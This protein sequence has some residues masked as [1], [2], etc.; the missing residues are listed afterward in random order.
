VNPPVRHSV[1]LAIPLVVVAA[2]MALTA[3]LGA[4]YPGPPC[5]VCD[6]AGPPISALSHGDF[7][8][9][10]STQTVMGS[11]SLV[12]RAPFAAAARLA[13]GDVLLQYRLGALACLLGVVGF[14]LALERYTTLRQRPLIVRLL[15]MGL[16]VANPLVFAALRWG[17]PEEALGAVLCAGAILL[18]LRGRSVAAGV[19][20]GLALATKQWAWL[21][22]LPLLIV[23]P[24]RA[25]FL[26]TAAGIAAVFT[27]PML[28]GDPGRF[29]AQIHH[30]GIP[31][32]GVTPAN[33]W[34]VYGHE[35]GYELTGGG[36]RGASSYA[37][38]DWMGHVS[39]PLVIVVALLLTA[40]YWRRRRDGDPMDIL[41]LVALVFLGR[42]ML[43][44]L[45]YSYHSLPFAMALLTFEATRRRVPVVSIYVAAWVWAMTKF[46]APIDNPTLL[47]RCYLAWA[48]PAAGYL[49][50]TLFARARQPAQR[51]ASRLAAA[52]T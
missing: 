38:P 27:L 9:F 31:G 32:N 1:L 11:F 29:L 2:L 22:L 26:M 12:L 4:D 13:G 19:A 15:A 36:F 18:A 21:A 25:R 48:V 51:T 5:S 3:P 33:I 49:A 52:A 46:V 40:A 23:V 45:S 8:T 7:G 35:G 17:H 37:L 24:N 43:D 42:T 20:I 47:N 30:Y 10:F 44:P 28:L 34:W 16:V 14:A 6:F 50:F 41:A 39:H